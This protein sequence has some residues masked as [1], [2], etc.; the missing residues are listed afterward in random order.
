MPAGVRLRVKGGQ[1]SSFA[2]AAA[3]VLAAC[4]SAP[5]ASVPASNARSSA[6]TIETPTGAA[7]MRAVQRDAWGDLVD[8]EGRPTSEPRYVDAIRLEADALGSD[9]RIQLSFV[10]APPPRL[11]AA[12]ERDTYLIGLDTQGDS[13]PEYLVRFENTVDGTWAA[14]LE[15]VIAAR[16]YAGADFAGSIVLQER[17]VLVQLPLSTIGAPSS[18]GICAG[19]QTVRPVDGHVL[20][21]D[22]VPGG[23]CLH[24]DAMIALR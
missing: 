24:G 12:L 15:D 10:G 7:P 9:L 20:A 3:I 14:S 16:R 4:V 18:L 23:D 8:G 6:Q 21:E 17:V 2:L 22:S 1:A 13:K 5:Q 11:A 19:S